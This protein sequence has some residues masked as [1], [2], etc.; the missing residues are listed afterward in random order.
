MVEEVGDIGEVLRRARQP[1]GAIH[2]DGID[3]SFLDHADK[4]TRG[5]TRTEGDHPRDVVVDEF[6]DH[7]HVESWSEASTSRELR[8]ACPKT[9]A[10]TGV[11]R[12]AF[13]GA[14]RHCGI[15]EHSF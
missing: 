13:F 6:V 9:R 7:S 12:Y 15:L 10:R 3:D 1:I 11:D 14:L 2:E 5:L 4:A 8:L